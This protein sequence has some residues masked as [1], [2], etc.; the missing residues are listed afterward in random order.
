M[1]AVLLAVIAGPARSDW[2]EP[3]PEFVFARLSCTNRE[4]WNIWPQYFPD[5]P[6]WHHD[7]PASDEF[8]IGLLHEL[9]GI[10][11]T[12]M[13]YKIVELDS[14]EIFKYPFLYLSE[15]G[16][17]AL[18]KKEIANLGEYIRRGGFIMAD[19]FRTAGYVSR[20]EELEV[21]RSYLKQAVPER[22]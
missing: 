12:P 1:L 13:S 18:N 3:T 10:R 6:P 9:T 16:F 15:P 19:D 2:F 21:L 7:Y 20:T 8:F 11:V 4:S 5:N 22:E 14:D 17:L